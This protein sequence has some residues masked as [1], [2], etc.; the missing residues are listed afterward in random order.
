MQEAKKFLHLL[1]FNFRGEDFEIDVIC[2]KCDKWHQFVS[3]DIMINV[4]PYLVPLWKPVVE[5]DYKT[6]WAVIDKNNREIGWCTRHMVIEL[7]QFVQLDDFNMYIGLQ[8]DFKFEKDW[9][10]TSQL[11]PIFSDVNKKYLYRFLD[12]NLIKGKSLKW[13]IYN[14]I[15][16]YEQRHLKHTLGRLGKTHPLFSWDEITD[17]EMFLAVMHW[18]NHDVDDG[19][20]SYVLKSYMIDMGFPKHR[21]NATINMAHQFQPEGMKKLLTMWA[22]MESDQFI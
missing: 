7:L 8:K 13:V 15:F 11:W 14:H 5:L 2:T 6:I 12:S 10:Y 19:E 16:N 1:G 4:A 18:I 17:G 22:T 20:M 21:L 9:S 3:E